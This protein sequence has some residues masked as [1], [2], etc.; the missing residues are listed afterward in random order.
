MTISPNKPRH[1]NGANALQFLLIIPP[2]ARR[3]CAHRSA[4][5]MT[6]IPK[7]F[8]KPLLVLLR[9]AAFIGGGLFAV[10]S[11]MWLCGIVIGFWFNKWTMPPGTTVKD[12]IDPIS[13]GF[14]AGIL[15]AGFI[16]SYLH[17]RH[18]PAL[19]AIL[20]SV[21]FAAASGW[22]FWDMSHDR[23]QIQSFEARSG[24]AHFYYTWFWWPFDS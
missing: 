3:A 23:Y 14:A 4:K 9:G 1:S 15:C 16:L 8:Q 18:R 6:A 21:L 7:D 13:S 5:I 10:S 20:F 17:S 12:L 2:F 19:A 24:C 22:F 11:G